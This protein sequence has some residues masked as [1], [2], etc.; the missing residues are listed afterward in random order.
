MF[1]IYSTIQS[2]S[3][4]SLYVLTLLLLDTI[5]RFYSENSDR[6]CFLCVLELDSVWLVTVAHHEWRSNISQ[7]L[8]VNIVKGRFIFTCL[9]KKNVF[10]N[11][12][13]HIVIL[14]WVYLINSCEVWSWQQQMRHLH[15]ALHF[16]KL[17]G[18]HVWLTKQL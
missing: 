16:C 1:F 17:I 4:Y 15:V 7:F 3:L 5:L 12:C 13:N 8:S 6:I 2:N 14:Y 18:W 10:S 11:S 9:Y